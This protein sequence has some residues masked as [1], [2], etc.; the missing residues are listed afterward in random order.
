MIVIFI[1]H[2]LQML[3]LVAMQVLVCNYVHFM[4]YATPMPYVV[5]LAY[6]SLDS[7]RVGNMLWA[8]GMGLLIDSFSNTPGEAAAALTL[9]AF[10]QWPLLRAMAPKECAED[11][12]PTYKSMGRWNHIRYL[13]ILALVH[14]VTLYLL[15]SFSFFHLTETLIAFASSLL[16]SFVLML[17][18]ET[19]RHGK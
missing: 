19:L 18:L 8:F 6:F 16:F 1:R 7:N 17:L 13:F 10:V 12:V 9:T 2:L 14:H 15:E 11:M 5:F 3:A 4:G